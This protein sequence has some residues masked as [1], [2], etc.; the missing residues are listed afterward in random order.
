MP[1][2]TCTRLHWGLQ[3]HRLEFTTQKPRVRTMDYEFR[4][5]GYSIHQRWRTLIDQRTF[6]LKKRLM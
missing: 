6:L 5:R 4:P 3:R 1:D 2:F